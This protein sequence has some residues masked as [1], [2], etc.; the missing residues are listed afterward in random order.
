MYFSNYIQD[1]TAFNP[2]YAGSQGAL[3]ITGQY[4][5]QWAR[6]N[7]GPASQGISIHA[8]VWAHNLG[9]GF[10]VTNDQ[11]AGFG[12][13]S[14]VPSFAYRIN[15]SEKRFIA[16]GI[17][18]AF[19]R[20]RPEFWNLLLL[21]PDD[22]AFA[23]SPPGFSASVGTGIYYASEKFYLGFAVPELFKDLGGEF[24]QAAY[25][26][27]ERAYIAHSGV[28]IKLNHEIKLKPN[29]L[30]VVPE[31]GTIYADANLLM[32]L[33]EVLWLGSSYR[34]GQGASCLAQLQLN[35]QLAVGYSYEL[36]VKD[37]GALGVSS[38]EISVQ[39]RFYFV[40]SDVKSPRY[41]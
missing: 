28:V 21:D 27:P 5:H 17:Q 32:L 35:P 10:R 8:P 13:Q 1:A 34:F 40:K 31:N 29:A 23:P 36:P 3:S 41:F 15:F 30:V 24:R 26:T 22:H 16:A 20:Q 9:V 38:H 2:A 33:R 39:Y 25:R 6:A 12:Q 37:R 18:A 7:R 14:L 4:R 11:L 19:I